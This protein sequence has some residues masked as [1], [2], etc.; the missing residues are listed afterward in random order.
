MYRCIITEEKQSVIF[1]YLDTSWGRLVIIVCAVSGARAAN[2]SN[3]EKFQTLFKEPFAFNKHIASHSNCFNCRKCKTSKRSLFYIFEL[4][5][6]RFFLFQRKNSFSNDLRSVL[7]N[8]IFLPDKIYLVFL[9]IELFTDFMWKMLLEKLSWCLCVVIGS[10]R[11]LQISAELFGS[12]GIRNMLIFHKSVEPTV[13]AVDLNC[14][15]FAAWECREVW[16]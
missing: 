4:F 12:S 16:M 11:F 9:L 15:V 14:S 13:A 2:Y 6:H 5:Q 1:T 7:I 3:F 8:L 10:D